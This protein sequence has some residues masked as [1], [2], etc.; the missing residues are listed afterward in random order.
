VGSSS[1][2]SPPRARVCMGEALVNAP[3]D[4]PLHL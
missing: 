4:L 1:A 3:R 2:A